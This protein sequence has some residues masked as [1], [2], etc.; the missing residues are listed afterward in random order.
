MRTEKKSSIKNSATRLILIGLLVL[1]QTG[2]M[3]FL[4][5]KLNTYSTAITL[6]LTFIAMFIAL[7]IFGGKEA[8]S[9]VEGHGIEQPNQ[10]YLLEGAQIT[11]LGEDILLESELL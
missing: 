7:K 8:P 10:A 11:Y 4:M 2:W 9:P 3:I 6:L 1:I 5:M